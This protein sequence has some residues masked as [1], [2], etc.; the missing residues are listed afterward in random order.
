MTDPQHGQRLSPVKAGKVRHRKDLV[1]GYVAGL[2][3]GAYLAL[4][5]RLG[6]M[7]QDNQRRGAVV[8]GLAD[9]GPAGQQPTGTHRG[10]QHGPYLITR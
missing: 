1:A 5:R 8:Q 10:A 7:R 2:S 4:K 9:G 6:I 3:A